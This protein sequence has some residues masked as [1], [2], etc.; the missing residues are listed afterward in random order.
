VA[1]TIRQR[2]LLIGILPPIALGAALS[3]LLAAGAILFGLRL[4]ARARAESQASLSR[5]AVSGRVLCETAQAEVTHRLEAAIAVALDQV[6][7]D[8]GIAEDR[9]SVGWKAESQLGGDARDVTLPRLLLGGR[10]LGQNTDPSTPTPAVD[11]ASRLGGAAVTVFQRMDEAGDMLR[12]A[13]TV[14]N[15]HGQR[16]IGT[17]IPIRDPDGTPSPVLAE[18]LAGRRYVGRAFVVDARYVAAYE[19]LRDPRGRVMGMLFVGVRQDAL[20]SIR[21]SLA[22]IR[23]GQTG[24]VVVLGA[25]GTQRGAWVVPPPGGK[26]GGAAGGA[27]ASWMH[28]APGADGRLHPYTAQLARRGSPGRSSRASTPPSTR[29]SRRSG[30]WP[31]CWS[32]SR[33]ATSRSGSPARSRATTPR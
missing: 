1:R 16:A 13:T 28:D 32:G 8:G 24:R 15:A 6:A 26:P 31:R 19:P 27:P 11:A 10:W 22:E 9:S 25:Q 21:R 14:R 30:R 20:E 23:I 17:F 29:S 4:T 3:L 18:V 33:A 7:C 2:L 12:V 5:A